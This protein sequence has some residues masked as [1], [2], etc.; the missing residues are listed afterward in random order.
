MSNY[1][2]K[3]ENDAWHHA[4]ENFIKSIPYIIPTQYNIAGYEWDPLYT[5]FRDY[6]EIGLISAVR[7][8]DRLRGSTEIGKCTESR[9]K[10]IPSNIIGLFNRMADTGIIW[11]L[12]EYTTRKTRNVPNILLLK[13][14]KYLFIPGSLNTGRVT[15]CGSGRS[16][17]D[18]VMEY[19]HNTIDDT[20]FKA[21]P[22]PSVRLDI[23][24]DISDQNNYIANG[25]VPWRP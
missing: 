5:F 22:I 4:R 14:N 9:L 3:V 6:A 2:K 25:T 10:G 20:I 11:V 16:Q 21:V 17:A 8:V 19:P 23:K 13:K 12:K 15:L 1:S 7:D 24:V 18:S